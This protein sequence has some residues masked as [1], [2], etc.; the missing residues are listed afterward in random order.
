MTKKKKIGI[1]ISLIII[2]VILF[3][4]LTATGGFD[5]LKDVESLQI[6]IASFGSISYLVYIGIFVLGAVFY[7][8]QVSSQ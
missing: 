2:V 4:V 5:L 8:L 6:W 3:S 7:C 1:W